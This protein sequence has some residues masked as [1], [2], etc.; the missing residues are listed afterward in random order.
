MF[1]QTMAIFRGRCGNQY[2]DSG[3]EETPKRWGK[4][5]GGPKVTEKRCIKRTTVGMRGPVYVPLRS[6]SSTKAPMITNISGAEDGG[7]IK[8][9]SISYS[10]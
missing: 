1:C 6:Y 7:V 5:Q 10:V 9:S 3:S 4:H 2:L 8:E